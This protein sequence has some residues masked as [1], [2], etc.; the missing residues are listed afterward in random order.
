MNTDL[1]SNGMWPSQ[2]KKVMVCGP[3]NFKESAFN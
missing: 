1:T 3:L 2:N